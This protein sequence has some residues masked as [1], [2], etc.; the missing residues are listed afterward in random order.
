MEETMIWK[1]AGSAAAA[2]ALLALSSTMDVAA[3]RHG[4]GGGHH[5]GG[6]Q[7]GGR[8]HFSAPSG[9]RAFSHVGGA[10]HFAFRHHRHFRHR[11]VGVG[12]YSYYYG[13]GCYWLKQR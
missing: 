8:A 7:F 1:I 13:N 6:G 12:G 5:G 11:V 4:G 3:A 9:H 2:L 10:R